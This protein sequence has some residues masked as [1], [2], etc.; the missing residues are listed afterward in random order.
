VREIHNDNLY[1]T[2][3]QS[4]KKQ[5]RDGRLQYVYSVKLQPILYLR[6]MKNYAKTMG[7]HELDDV[8]PNAYSGAKPLTV[9]WT[10]DAHARQLVGVDYGN[11]HQ[12]K[13]AGYGLSIQT[14]VPAHPISATELQKRLTNVQ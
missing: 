13:Y 6:L 10:V 3:F 9:Q 5:H 11:G 14:A 1:D 4:V 7:L 8:D 2:S 12:E